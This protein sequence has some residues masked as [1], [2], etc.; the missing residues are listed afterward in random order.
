MSP[1]YAV[2]WEDVI[3]LG[4]HKNRS[5]ALDYAIDQYNVHQAEPGYLILGRAELRELVFHGQYAL[6]HMAKPE[7]A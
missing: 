7:G 4:K 6:T 2:T 3:D 1:F 5:V